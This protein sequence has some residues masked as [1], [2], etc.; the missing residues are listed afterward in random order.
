[1]KIIFL[2]FFTLP[3][4]THALVK[5][6]W[7]GISGFSLSD[8]K[9]TLIFDPAMTRIGFLDYLPFV[10]LSIDKAEV[11]YWFSR[12]KI[13]KVDG[14]FVNHAHT[15]HVMDAPY[16]VT[17][18]G[19]KLYGSSSVKNV[20]L[21]H[22]VNAQNIHELKSGEEVSIGEFKIK[23]VETKH[24]PHVLGHILMDGD[25]T[26]PLLPGS[27]GWD[28]KVGTTFSYLIRY[29]D[30]KILF[31][32][33]SRIYDPDIFMNETPDVLLLTIANRISTEELVEKRLNR[34]KP[35]M[36]IPLHH[37]NFFFKMNRTGPIDLFW[38]IKYEEFKE[39]SKAFN[40]IDP[41]YCEEVVLF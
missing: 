9:T 32:A 2:L 11:D 15:D 16:V 8:E 30:K 36:V 27:S 39:K 12:C 23:A 17:K 34:L 26:K 19:G 20:G 37:D 6:N 41:K 24:G 35:K 13:L 4:A 18:Y 25:I 29:K 7:F 14:T 38:G 40:V 10:K 1:M 31:Q 21:G 3:I 28:Y 5:F 33:V 22:G